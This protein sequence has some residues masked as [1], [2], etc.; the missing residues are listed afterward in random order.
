MNNV[1]V[2]A[3]GKLLLYGD[4]SVVH[5]HPCI[6]TAVD[7]RMY[8]TVQESA[9]RQLCVIAPDVDTQKYEKAIAQ[10][11]EGT[12]PKSVA[13]IEHCYKRFLEKHPQ[14][15][16]I[17]VT[18][19]S[20]FSSLFGFGSSSAVTVAFAKALST[21]YSVTLSNK[22]LFDLCYS[23]VID[24]QGV[25]SGFD[26]AVAIWGGTIYYVSPAKTVES[27]NCPDL[28]LI[29]GYTGVK[30]DTPTLIRQVAQQKEKHPEEVE[31][32]F[33]SIT[34]IVDQSKVCL[35]KQDWHKAGKLLTEN[36][37]LL[38]KLH[39][40]STV[41]DNLINAAN[42]AGAYGAKLS[43]AGGGDCMIAF[44]DAAHHM[45]VIEAIQKA[46]GT[47]MSVSTNA[48]GVRIEK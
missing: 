19:K 48:T 30:A 42:L 9:K 13:F 6:V 28:P 4:H 40:S 17:V 45:R 1:T 15:T 25:G 44:C 2:S 23:A 43:G 18:T 37:Q 3:P 14:S 39:V 29:V 5:G 41:L 35:E 16:G 26:I 46:G 47:H 12:T 31:H 22:E 8:V 34:Q 36:Q 11:G 21:L 33:Q 7:Q 10:L 27:V 24:V 32:I 20:D 38:R